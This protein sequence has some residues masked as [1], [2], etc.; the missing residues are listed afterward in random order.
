MLKL[1]KL[2]NISNKIKK[3]RK[4]FLLL[5]NSIIKFDD[6]LDERRGNQRRFIRSNS[7]RNTPAK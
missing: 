6:D 3:Q 1:T 4:I 7:R 2:T 5:F